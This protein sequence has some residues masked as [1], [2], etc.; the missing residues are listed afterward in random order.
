MLG[1]PLERTW[2]AQVRDMSGCVLNH[3]HG[4]LYIMSTWQM[5]QQQSLK[6]CPCSK[7]LTPEILQEKNAMLLGFFP[8]LSARPQS[9]RAQC[10]RACV[11][12]FVCVCVGRVRTCYNL[13]VAKARGL[14]WMLSYNVDPA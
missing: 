10:V 8:M 5:S 2:H 12:A 1:A 9:F 13:E 3:E 14:I 11:C 7:F 6:P 4:A